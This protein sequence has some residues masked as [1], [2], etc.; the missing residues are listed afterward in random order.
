MFETLLA[1]GSL[2]LG[3][4]SYTNSKKASEKSEMHYYREAALNRQIGAFNARVIEYAGDRNIETLARKTRAI[5]SAQK[6]E[7]ARRG[8]TLDGSAA[9]VVQETINLAREE[10]LNIAFNTKVEKT[11]ALFAAEGA[12]ARARAG[13]SQALFQGKQAELGLFQTFL[14]GL[15]GI[16]GAM[17]AESARAEN[18]GMMSMMGRTPSSTGGGGLLGMLQGASETVRA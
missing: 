14:T 15:K 12:S 16:G 7:F 13:A 2:G 6:N 3:L 18:Q 10:A 17:G 9:C 11:N 4:M 8:I 1:L 5:V